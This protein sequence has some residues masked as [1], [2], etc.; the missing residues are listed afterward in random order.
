MAIQKKHP[1]GASAFVKTSTF[2]K[3]S[4]DRTA[5]KEVKPKE[6]VVV[7]DVVTETTERVEIIEGADP[8]SSFKEKMVEEEFSVGSNAPKKNYMWPILLI[9]I[10]AILLLIGV[11]LYK[12]GRN[13][14]SK[15]NVAT[16]SPSPT[17]APEPTKTI[18]LAK[19]EIEILNGGG[20]SGEAS[21][22]KTSLETE[23]FTVSSIGNADNSDYADTI[24]KAKAQVDEDFITKLKSVLNDSFTVGATEVLAEDSSVP[25][26][27][28]IGTKK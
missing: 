16:L 23:G 6:E 28:I 10:I 25:V 27:V 7:S 14:N 5:D 17:V 4:A 26:V 22:Q 11:F 15:V 3:A 2:A 19:Y 1:A 13:T 21:R 9:F 24:I 18:D 8:L 20:V 12:S